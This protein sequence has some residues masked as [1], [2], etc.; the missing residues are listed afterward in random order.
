MGDNTSFVLSLPQYCINDPAQFFHSV[1]AVLYFFF[2]ICLLCRMFQLIILVSIVFISFDIS[3][4]GTFS[5]DFC[6]VPFSF[7]MLSLY[8]ESSMVRQIFICLRSALF[9][10][11]LTVSITVF[12][13]SVKVLKFSSQL[14]LLSVLIQS[15]SYSFDF[16]SCTFFSFRFLV[17]NSRLV[18]FINLVCFNICIWSDISFKMI[19]D[20][21]SLFNWLDT[22]TLSINV[23]VQCLFLV[24]LVI[25]GACHY[26][27]NGQ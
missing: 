24:S 23:V 8:H 11:G 26:L 4:C 10:S 5:F 19:A 27:V 18:L 1:F 9:F 20:S 6:K 14:P 15:T 25:V 16:I 21:K 17:L 22:N 13:F 7:L 3:F 2:V 12:S